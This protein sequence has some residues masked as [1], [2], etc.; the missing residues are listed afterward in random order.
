MIFLFI[1]QSTNSLSVAVQPVTGVGRALRA[2]LGPHGV[3]DVGMSGMFSENRRVSASDLEYRLHRS[4][5]DGRGLRVA[6][7]F[8]DAVTS[9]EVGQLRRFRFRHNKDSAALHRKK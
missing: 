4:V 6:E 3:G 1:F 9:E 2:H 7:L 5:P 8:R